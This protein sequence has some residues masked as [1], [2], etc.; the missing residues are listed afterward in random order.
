MKKITLNNGV[1]SP[2]LGTGTNT[3]GKENN[4]YQGKLNGNFSALQSAI[5]LGYRLVDTA[6][7]Y[8]NEAGVGETVAKSG[9]PREEFFLTTKIP[10]KEKY[11]GNK[12]AVRATIDNSLKNLQTDVIDLYLI[13][14]PIEEERLLQ[15]TWEVLEEYTKVGKLKAI[16]VSNF[17]V[18]LLETLKKYATIQPA[19]NQIESNPGNWNDEIIEYCLKNGI[20]PE[21]WGPMK[22][23]AEQREVL[24]KV[25]EK[26]G[27]SWAQVLL[28]YQIERGVMVIPKS[29]NP[30]NQQ[31]N[32]DVFDFS[33]TD[34]DKIKISEL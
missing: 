28:A 8:R 9:V 10:P 25:G 3:Y 32:L 15:S 16:G 5:E 29:H 13:H 21:A 27:K 31:A 23:N 2:V 17:S 33:L 11:I 6:I 30:K 34:T 12:E 4:D 1:K 19:V 14:H 7:S 24:N 26:F 18:E 20:V 22:T